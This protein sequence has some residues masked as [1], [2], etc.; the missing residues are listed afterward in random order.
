MQQR[1]GVVLDRLTG[2]LGVIWRRVGVSGKRR[3]EF[4]AYLWGFLDHLV[5]FLTVS[6][7]V[8]SGLEASWKRPESILEAFWG[9]YKEFF[10]V[11]KAILQSLIIWNK[12]SFVYET[13]LES[14]LKAAWS[15]FK[16]GFAWEHHLS[17]HERKFLEH[18]KNHCF[19]MISILRV[20]VESTTNTKEAVK[21]RSRNRTCIHKGLEVDF[22]A[23]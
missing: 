21:Q 8:G 9:V 23:Y 15:T 12:F 19:S 10:L 2:V 11:F 5:E 16:I 6:R 4:F 20:F 14:F 3:G 18:C 17:G 13:K 7:R 1:L 22:S